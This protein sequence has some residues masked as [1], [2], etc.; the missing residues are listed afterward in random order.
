MHTITDSDIEFFG[1]QESQFIINPSELSDSVKKRIGGDESVQGD[2]LPWSKTH[3]CVQLRMG[4]VS[5]WAGING[6]GKTQLLGQ[7]CAWGL[8]S[9]T[10]LNASMEMKPEASMERMV[11]QVA[12]NAEPPDEYIDKFLNWTDNRLWIYDQTDS[13]KPERILGIVHYA[14]NKLGIKHIIIDSLMKCGIKPDDYSG[15]ADFVDRLCWAAKS[16]DIHIH[17]VHHIRK[18]E[19]EKK[20][21]DKFDIKGAGEII[22]MVDNVF[23]VHR[24]KAKEEKIRV[25]TEVS[26]NDPDC[27]LK[28]DKQ[29]HNA[30]EG[31]FKLWFHKE[32]LQYIPDNRYAVM[33]YKAGG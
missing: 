22:D 19:T 28:V 5:V 4:E 31:V 8:K 29:R 20:V 32:S 23:I 33:P 25:G 1:N 15:Q 18:G 2:L 6:H 9:N 13:V 30:W 16:L 12:G 7:V 24:N 21:P 17:L 14:A 26:E 10:W 11:K 27:I 3:N